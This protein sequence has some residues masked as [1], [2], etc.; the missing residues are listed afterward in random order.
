MV[1]QAKKGFLVAAH[2]QSIGRNRGAGW[3]TGELQQDTCIDAT[4]PEPS[5]IV[6]LG[7]LLIGACYYLKRRVG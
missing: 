5:P 4:V 2:V 6:P 3:V 7:T 1:Q